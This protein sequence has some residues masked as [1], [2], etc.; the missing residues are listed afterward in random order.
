MTTL[1]TLTRGQ[2]A[3]DAPYTAADLDVIADNVAPMH[4]HPNT[5]RLFT[6]PGGLAVTE[7][8]IVQV[9]PG[10]DWLADRA[11]RNDPGPG[12]RDAAVATRRDGVGCVHP[13]ITAW[14][15]ARGWPTDQHGRPVNP[16]YASLLA[17]PR[18]GLCTGLGPSWRYGEQVVTDA[19]AVAD[20]HVALIDR[21]T[22]H[23]GT[24]PA[25]PGGFAEPQDFGLTFADWT[26]GHRPVTPA[27]IIANALRELGE[28]T[29]IATPDGSTLR[30][31]RE[32][33]PV[34]S[35]HTL[36]AWTVVYT[37]LVVLPTRQPVPDG[38]RARWTPLDTLDAVLPNMWGDHRN[39]LTA[40]LDQMQRGL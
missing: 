39:A 29:G 26:T 27:G 30:I 31:V 37:V 16:R 17:D 40:A 33:R 10:F 38:F 15:I 34:S 12:S 2:G 4:G 13:G 11:H 24:I 23:N 25:L 8:G 14:A 5:P 21:D 19:V 35:P 32:I 22:P 28:E 3:G 6:G 1:S 18:I 7:D 36:N 9:P 20:G